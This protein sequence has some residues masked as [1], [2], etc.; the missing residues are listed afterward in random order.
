[1]VNNYKVSQTLLVI[2]L[3]LLLCPAPT[4]EREFS[5]FPLVDHAGREIHLPAETAKIYAT[6]EA[7]LFLVYALNPEAIIGWNRGLS[8]DLEFAVQPQYHHLPTLGTWDN[9]YKTIHTDLVLQQKPDLIL[10][11]APADSE[12]IRLADEIQKELKTPT[13]LL[14]SSLTSLPDSLQALGELLNK[15]IR[16]N[17]LA[18]FVKNHLERVSE[19]QK[20]RLSY[21]KIPVH[22]ISSH[23]KGYFDEILEL[24]GMVE[25]PEWTNTVP[26]P[27]FVLILPHSIA[28][29]YGEIQKAGFKRIY[30]V[31]SF[32]LNWLD[33]SVFGLLGLE[34]LLSIAYPHSYPGDL[35]ETYRAFMEVFFRVDVTT[36]M[37]DWTLKRSGISY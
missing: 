8:P 18:A 17:A 7:G 11:Y 5:S 24:A 20:L 28:D 36:P 30:Q 3:L 29:P 19:F 15:Q 32:P 31:P 12:N 23:P 26:L 16:A 33:P 1:M 37:L 35:A 2:L 34:W 27:D 9:Q 14:D 10:H 21:G 22:L 4:H 25:L 6:T 13:V